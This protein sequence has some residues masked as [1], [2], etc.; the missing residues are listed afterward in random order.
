MRK[1]LESIEELHEIR[2]EFRNAVHRIFGSTALI[3]AHGDRHGG[4][5]FYAYTPTTGLLQSFFGES[6]IFAHILKDEK[7]F[8]ELMQIAQQHYQ[9]KVIAKITGALRDLAEEVFLPIYKA[10]GVNPKWTD[11]VYEIDDI[12]GVGGKETIVK[13]EIKD[14]VMVSRVVKYARKGRPPVWTSAKLEQRIRSAVR[15]FRKRKYRS[16]TLAEA[17]GEMR[18]PVTTLKKLLQRYGLRY[19]FYK[20]ET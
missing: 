12:F 8:E 17:A 6:E 4:T 2:E 18:M 11:V 19:S 15:T 10:A 14:G 3:G 5:L 9:S 13:K 1:P 7:L 16:P 20:K